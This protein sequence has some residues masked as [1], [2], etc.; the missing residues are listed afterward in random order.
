[1]DSQSTT[2]HQ[3][4][5]VSLDAQRKALEEEAEEL[6]LQLTSPTGSD[7]TG[8][9]IG[10]DTPLVDRDGYPRADIDLYLARTLRGRLAE[11][12]TDHKQLMKEMESIML[13][14]SSA[15]SN[16]ETDKTQTEQEARMQKKPK[17]KYDPATGKWVVKNWDG[18]ITGAGSSNGDGI[19]AFDSIDSASAPTPSALASIANLSVQSES[20]PATT[21]TTTQQETSSSS[22]TIPVTDPFAKVDGVAADSPASLAG[23][24]ENDLIVKFGTITKQSCLADGL[25]PLQQVAQLV[26]AAAGEQQ[27]ISLF[28]RRRIG[29]PDD[30]NES[31][32]SMIHM[33][34][35]TPKPW[36]GRGLL[37]CHIVPV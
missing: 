17:P 32:P 24:Q 36:N 20:V 18:T 23:L 31:A 10:I 19:R 2:Q 25:D 34:Q 12:Q 22:S 28:I 21:T 29:N 1:M 6:T 3:Q 33:L 8:P 13:S 11:I 15:S 37:G 7:L 14:N 30:D 27:S 35:L 5:L 9:P 16:G 26:P 4:K